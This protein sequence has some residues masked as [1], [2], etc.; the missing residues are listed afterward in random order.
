MKYNAHIHIIMKIIT[1]TTCTTN[2]QIYHFKRCSTSYIHY[3]KTTTAQHTKQGKKQNVKIITILRINIIPTFNINIHFDHFNTKSHILNTFPTY[4]Y[5]HFRVNQHSC[6]RGPLRECR[7]IRSGASGLPY[8]CASICV[9]FG[10][11]R[12]ASCVDSKPK[13]KLHVCAYASKFGVHYG[14]VFETG[15]SGLPYYCTPP[16]CVPDVLGALT[17]WRHTNIYIY[18]YIY[19]EPQRKKESLNHVPRMLHSDLRSG[20]YSFVLGACAAPRCSLA[21]TRGCLQQ[22][23]KQ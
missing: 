7:S 17:V 19:I 14:G 2:I 3:S 8:Y 9:R 22:G 1:I 18:I 16:V 20:G 10:C 11:T 12:R 23:C 4:K 15:A 21:K 5:I 6:A 13:K